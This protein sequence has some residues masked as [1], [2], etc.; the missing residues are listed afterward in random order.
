MEEA[1]VEVVAEALD[2]EPNPKRLMGLKEPFESFEEALSLITETVLAEAFEET[3]GILVGFGGSAVPAPFQT[4]FTR[5]FAEDRNPN[6]D[7][8]PLFSDVHRSEPAHWQQTA[9]HSLRWREMDD[10]RSSAAQLR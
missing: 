3:T 2:P 1:A 6:L 7:A 4:L 8:V 9:T 5:F 10:Q